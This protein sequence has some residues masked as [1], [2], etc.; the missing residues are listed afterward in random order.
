M[1]IDSFKEIKDNFQMYP[2]LIISRLSYT[3]YS[4]QNKIHNDISM[5]N[6]ALLLD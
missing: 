3:L 6:I 2:K 5:V 4:E 1:K